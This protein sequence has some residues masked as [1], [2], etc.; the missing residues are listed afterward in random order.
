MKNK[1]LRMKQLYTIIISLTFGKLCNFFSVKSFNH[2][3]STFFTAWLEDV[4]GE[5]SSYFLHDLFR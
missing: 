3:F 5:K 2:F 1:I 4:H